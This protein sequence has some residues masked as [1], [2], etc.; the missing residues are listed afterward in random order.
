[1]AYFDRG[2]KKLLEEA[3]EAGREFGVDIDDECPDFAAWLELKQ[4]GR[5]HTSKIS[6]EVRKE[7]DEDQKRRKS[8]W[9][10]W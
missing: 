8:K 5:A 1:M 7:V 9:L 3:F 2:M 6:R 10:R 4:T